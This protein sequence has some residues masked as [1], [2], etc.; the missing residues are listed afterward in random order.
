MSV[1]TTIQN[2]ACHDV[3]EAGV[4]VVDAFYTSISRNLFYRI[5]WYGRHVAAIK[6]TFTPATDEEEENDVYRL[7]VEGNAIW[8]VESHLYE[9]STNASSSEITDSNV[10]SLDAVADSDSRNSHRRQ[11]DGFQR[12]P[13]RHV[14]IHTVF[15][16][17]KE[18]VVLGPGNARVVDS[19]FSR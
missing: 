9:R 7:E 1:G 15:T 16:F 2:C 13:L 4:N 19:R 17:R 10:L 11:L 5:G 6:R 18:Y 12:G 14:Q 3:G 8:D